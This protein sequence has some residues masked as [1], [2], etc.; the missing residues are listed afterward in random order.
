MAASADRFEALRGQKLLE[1]TRYLQAQGTERWVGGHFFRGVLSL[2]PSGAANRVSV[3]VWI[4]WPDH[5]PLRR[6]LAEAHYRFQIRRE[7]TDLSQ[8]ARAATL[9]EAEK[10]IR[11]AF[12]WS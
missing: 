10:V 4:D 1:L 11:Q 9:E 2:V 7:D 12:G 6:E 8:D 5:A 3:E